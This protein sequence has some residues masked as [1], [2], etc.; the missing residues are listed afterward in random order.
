MDKEKAIIVSRQFIEYLVKKG[1]K[2]KEAFLFGSFI[3]GRFTEDS[4]IDIALFVEDISNSYI[5]MINMMKLRRK[6]DLRIEPHPF[7]YSDFTSDNPFAN[8]IKRVGLPLI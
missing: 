3:N 5:E 8:E 7:H 1:Y 4:D 2:I 6:F